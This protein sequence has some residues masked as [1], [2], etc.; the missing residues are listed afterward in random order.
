MRS[1]NASFQTARP[2]RGSRAVSTHRPTG[3]QERGATIVGDDSFRT[4]SICPGQSSTSSTKCSFIGV[5]G[6]QD[7]KRGEARGWSRHA[8]PALALEGPLAS[9]HPHDGASFI[10]GV[11]EGL[12]TNHC[13]CLECVWELLRT[14]AGLTSECCTSIGRVD[15]AGWRER[16]CSRQHATRRYRARQAYNT[17]LYTQQT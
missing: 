3:E 8:H 15:P 11:I 14:G 6:F 12:E 17:L 5:K 2:T 13:C 1:G 10:G 7:K 9:L 4:S 16:D